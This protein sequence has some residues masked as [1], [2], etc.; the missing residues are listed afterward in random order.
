MKYTCRSTRGSYMREQTCAPLQFLYLKS[1]SSTLS[2]MFI[3]IDQSFV[4]MVMHAGAIGKFVCRQVG[5]NLQELHTLYKRTHLAGRNKQSIETS[6]RE[7]IHFVSRRSDMCSA[8]TFE[9]TKELILLSTSAQHLPLWDEQALHDNRI[10]HLACHLGPKLSLACFLLLGT[11]QP[12]N[13]M[14]NFCL[15]VVGQFTRVFRLQ[16]QNLR[17][18][19]FDH[20][21]DDTHMC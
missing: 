15:L 9:V 4:R 13:P 18:L 2:C 10:T 16:T 14:E 20:C 1:P 17:R 6:I 3:S 21:F 11:L 12:K 19:S 7:T 8:S 5:H